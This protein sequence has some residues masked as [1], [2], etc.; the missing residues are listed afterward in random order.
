MILLAEVGVFKQVKFA[1]MIVQMY[2][3]M[4]LMVVVMFVIKIA[5]QVMEELLVVIQIIQPISFVKVTLYILVEL[6]TK[7]VLQVILVPMVHVF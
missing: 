6:Y 1:V 5:K 7:P 2:H 3:V 4:V